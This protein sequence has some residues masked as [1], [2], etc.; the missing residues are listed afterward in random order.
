M[1]A[2]AGYSAI[3]CLP[4][5]GSVSKATHIGHEGQ[6]NA[7]CAAQ[8]GEEHLGAT[9]R[10]GDEGSLC[11]QAADQSQ[12]GSGGRVADLQCCHAGQEKVHGCG[13]NG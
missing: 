13:E 12:R 1:K 7:V 5:E 3:S 8:E 4:G 6:Q 2:L 9:D 11:G 10:Q